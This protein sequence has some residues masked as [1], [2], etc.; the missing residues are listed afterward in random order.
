MSKSNNLENTYPFIWLD[1][2]IE[3]AMNPKL[4]ET[5][6]ISP[7]ELAQIKE[8]FPAETRLVFRSLK[9]QTLCLFSNEKIRIV[10]EQY[11]LTV[12]ELAAQATLNMK[13]DPGNEQ[14]VKAG[15]VILTELAALS[16]NIHTRYRR[17][18]PKAAK[19]TE[20]PEKINE[21]QRLLFKVLLSLSVDQISIILKSAF[22]VKVILSSS[23]RKVCKVIAPY[24]STERQ[25]NI[26]EAGMRTA[27]IKQEDRDKVIAV[28][29]LK[30]IIDDIQQH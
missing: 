13:Y 1:E 22:N 29:T 15:Q 16:D 2:V 19:T 28:E 8:K 30:K 9:L 24:V 7:A 26:S 5:G 4:T 21:F 14:W 27:S 23:Y 11:D 17:Y 10:V 6:K 25:E 12:R 18:L 3:I 20:P